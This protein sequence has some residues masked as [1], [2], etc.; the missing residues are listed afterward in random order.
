MPTPD[1]TRAILAKPVPTSGHR[2]GAASEPA[3][4]ACHL[5]PDGAD[6]DV[7]FSALM[8]DSDRPIV[9][10]DATGRV[11]I[12][13]DQAAKHI[14]LERAD[15]V[16]D[17]TFHDNCA[18]DYADERV[19]YI[20]EAIETGEAFAVEGMTRG[21]WRR[22][23]VRRLGST[24]RAAQLALLVHIPVPE[25]HDEPSQVSYAVR[26]ARVDDFGDLGTLSERELEVLKLIS[27]GLT[28]A[29]IAKS[30]HRSVKTVE[31][32]RVS[33]GNKLGLSNRVELARLAIRAGL[34]SLNDALANP[35]ETERNQ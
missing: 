20:R 17:Q 9:V 16:I 11:V 23:I 25:E 3:G 35:R 8:H 26:R 12:C 10:S 30:L 24:G 34:V 13:N 14:G 32:H 31:W 27:Q 21:R 33:L 2:N 18:S 19:A 7:L 6:V 22:T 5:A 29:E 1:Q 15:Q 4:P 28:T